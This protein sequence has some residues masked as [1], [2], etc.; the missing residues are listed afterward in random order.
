[1]K[2]AQIF[3]IVF[4]FS[5]GAACGDDD[6]GSCE[7]TYQCDGSEC[8]GTGGACTS[9]EQLADEGISDQASCEAWAERVAEEKNATVESATFDPNGDC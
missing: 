4:L 9:A 1:M 5:F 8:V 2:R 3:L 7:I 6:A